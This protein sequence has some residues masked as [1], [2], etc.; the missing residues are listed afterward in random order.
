V[1]QWSLVAPSFACPWTTLFAAG[2]PLVFQWV[3]VAP[4]F[5]RPWATIIRARKQGRQRNAGSPACQ[6]RWTRPA[7]MPPGYSG[8][9]LAR[10]LGFKAATT[11]VT[12]AAPPDYRRWLE[13][14]PDGVTFTNAPSGR[15]PVEAAHLFVTRRAD[16][17]RHLEVLRRRLADT[18]FIWVSWPKK[19]RGRSR[20]RDEGRSGDPWNA[21][22]VPATNTATDITEDVIREVALPLGFV[23]IKV[24]AVSEVWSGLKLVIRKSER[25]TAR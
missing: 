8:T 18:G 23:D 3:A 9:P 21:V 24:C 11:V 16:M 6:N 5:A 2:I 22:G 10:K 13:G 20:A 7:A 17:K 1:F 25:G 15:V 14:L 4:S 12:I 19:A